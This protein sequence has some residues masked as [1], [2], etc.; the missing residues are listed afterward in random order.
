MGWRRAIMS[1]VG[2]WDL[3]LEMKTTLISFQKKVKILQI[4]LLTTK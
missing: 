3:K 4:T 2:V 1:T